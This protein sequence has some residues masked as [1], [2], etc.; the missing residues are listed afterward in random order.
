MNKDEEIDE[1]NSD[2]APLQGG[3]NLLD[4]IRKMDKK[5]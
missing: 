1:D 2:E 4:T 3:Q 5:Q